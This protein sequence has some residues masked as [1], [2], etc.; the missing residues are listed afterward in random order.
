M[1]LSPHPSAVATLDGNAAIPV[2]A[3]S[4]RRADRLFWAIADSARAPYSSLITLFVFSAYFTTMVAGDPVRGQA[5]WSAVA[6]VAALLIGIGAI[7]IGPIADAGGRVKTWLAACVILA[8]PALSALWFATPGMVDGLGWVML[9]LVFSKVGIE[10]Y[11]VFINALLPR[12]GPR[13]SMGSLSGMGI[14]ACNFAN[15]A[16]LLIF[17]FAWSWTATPLFGLD[18]AVGEP[19]R[20][21]G[22]MTALWLILFSLPLFLFSPDAPATGLSFTETM[23]AGLRSLLRTLPKLRAQPN[24]TR[25]LIARTIYNQG[26]IVLMMFSG[27]LAAGVLHWTPQMLVVQG[28]LNSF[29]AALSGFFVGPLDRKAGTK[30]SLILFVSGAM[31]AN[32][33]LCTI[34]PSSI[35]FITLPTS[36]DGTMFPLIADKIFVAVNIGIA[37]TVSGAIAASRTMMAKLAPPAMLADFFSLYALS[38]TVTSFVG[39]LAIGLVTAAF[40][41]QRAGVAVGILFFV[42]GLLLFARVARP[43]S[44]DGEP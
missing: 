41:S 40:H 4:V 43:A 12:M 31:A 28:L 44:F 10:F 19:Q 21:A 9:A 36:S 33:L 35:L 38:G 13:S 25:Y 24:A 34:S 3:V 1:S 26:L 32:V 27:I 29:I 39:P 30:T 37:V 2:A 23:R 7:V 8:V 15:F 6:A 14:L 22:P 18:M 17:L 42:V 5:L 20:A 11:Q 16:V